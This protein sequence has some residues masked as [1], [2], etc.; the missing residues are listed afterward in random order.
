[1][2]INLL[3]SVTVVFS[4]LFQFQGI[5]QEINRDPEQR[6]D[7]AN[8]FYKPRYTLFDLRSDEPIFPKEDGKYHIYYASNEDKTPRSFVGSA[9]E[10]SSLFQYKFKDLESCKLWCNG[11]PYNAN[12]EKTAGANNPNS[13]NTTIS[14]TDNASA[15]QL[16]KTTTKS[17]P[18]CIEGDCKDGYGIF[19]FSNAVYKGN[20]VNGK[21]DGYGEMFYNDGDVIKGNFKS[22]HQN[23][24]C[25]TYFSN[26]DVSI[27]DYE[28]DL[29]INPVSYIFGQSKRLGCISGN[30]VTGFGTKVYPNGEYT[31][32][33]LNGKEH[34]KGILVTSTGYRY[35]GEF[36]DGQK[37]GR[38]NC[39]W[40]NGNKYDG[41]FNNGVKDGKGKF[42]YLGGKVYDGFWKRDK[43]EGQGTIIFTNGDSYTGN[44]LNGLHSGVGKYTWA[45][46]SYYEGG[47]LNG[48]KNGR[49]KEKFASGDI[50]D[51]QYVDGQIQQNVIG[52]YTYLNGNVKSGRWI[53]NKWEPLNE[54][55]I[56]SVNS[57]ANNTNPTTASSQNQSETEAERKQKELEIAK[58]KEFEEASEK[59][60]VVNCNYKF[61]K[62]KL[63]IE[64]IDNRVE[65]CYCNNYAI[66]SVKP[67]LVTI[68]ESAYIRER[69]QIHYEEVNA[70]EAHRES[71]EKRLQNFIQTNYNNGALDPGVS[72]YFMSV[73]SM[74]TVENMVWTM[75]LQERPKS[76]GSLNRKV[77]KYNNSKSC[78]NHQGYCE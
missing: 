1:M 25:T 4:L 5:S 35:E 60:K 16:Q 14:N 63:N 67:N 15:H 74:L 62:P 10:L 54:Q 36:K 73:A 20:W 40:P 76:Y 18:Y 51:G 43:K 44:W 31:G 49:G 78:K 21:R 24:R 39:I 41:E 56:N 38:G 34:G 2:N 23:G 9:S 8:V 12:P 46:G 55:D 71:D 42:Y 3:R 33:F 45:D 6:K 77:K 69:L 37:N 30:C 11:I 57:N 17:N 59:P 48:K 53:N 27:D 72:S 19:E 68:E 61:T 26:G 70:D 64:Y 50:Y 65:C 13:V 47:W 66:Y 7:Y 58:E 22:D 52:T 75:G 32:E 29:Q 28:N